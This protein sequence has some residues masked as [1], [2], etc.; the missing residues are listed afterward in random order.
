MLTLSLL[1]ALAAP[2]PGTCADLPTSSTIADQFTCYKDSGRKIIVPGTGFTDGFDGPGCIAGV[3]ADRIQVATCG[4]SSFNRR[5]V[6]VMFASIRSVEDEQS[7]PYVVLRL[8]GEVTS[9]NCAVV[10]CVNSPQ[11]EVPAPVVRPR[12]AQRPLGTAAPRKP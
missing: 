5:T 2:A 6:M 12:P 7:L 10:N 11:V 4:S 1:L 8:V 3:W 9:V